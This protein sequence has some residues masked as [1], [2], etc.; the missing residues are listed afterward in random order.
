MTV[1][2]GV[3]LS[4]SATGCALITTDGTTYSTDTWTRLSTGRRSDTLTDRRDRLAGI[5]GDVVSWASGAD[6][7][8][9]EGPSFGSVGGSSHDRSGLW[10]MVVER[11]VAAECPVVVVAP[12]TRAK[13]AAGSG[14]ADKAAVARAVTR[15]WPQW[16]PGIVGKLEDQADALALASIGCHLLGLTPFPMPKWRVEAL[17]KLE[18]PETLEDVA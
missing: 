14:R 2:A 8:V 4:L 12:T 18:V 10:W 13:W 7:V 16:E 15:M 9:V 11:L 1:I 17:S 3:D 6:L 5:R